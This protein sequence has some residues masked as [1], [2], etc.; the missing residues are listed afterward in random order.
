[1]SDW[2]STFISVPKF[3]VGVGV[4]L[5][6][7]SLESIPLPE[8]FRLETGAVLAGV[9]YDWF[10]C[11]LTSIPVPIPVP[12][13]LPVPVV[14]TVV[15]A[16]GMEGSLESMAERMEL[17]KD[18][19]AFETTGRGSGAEDGMENNELRMEAGSSGPLGALT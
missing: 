10:P 8:V 12:V 2:P 17:D 7:V 19:F 11:C 3:E 5:F 9:V 18:M 13:P 16:F 15:A 4:D 14:V 6:S 1:M